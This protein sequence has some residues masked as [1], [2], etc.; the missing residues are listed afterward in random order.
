MAAGEAGRSRS[1][2]NNVLVTLSRQKESILFY[3][4]ET[5]FN[6]YSLKQNRTGSSQN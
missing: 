6:W 3:R 1:P 5:E 4:R 2:F